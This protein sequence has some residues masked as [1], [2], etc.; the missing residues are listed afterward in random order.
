MREGEGV[1]AGQAQR[2]NKLGRP[3]GEMPR[4]GQDEGRGGLQPH[5]LPRISAAAAPEGR[6]AEV[7][8][9]RSERR[10]GGR[11]GVGGG[12]L[13]PGL[14]GVKRASPAAPGRPRWEVGSAALELP[15]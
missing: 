5:S 1:P 8:G 7:P 15:V 2:S 14:H 10:R 9:R 11:W 13:G 3:R 12:A 4:S 6:A